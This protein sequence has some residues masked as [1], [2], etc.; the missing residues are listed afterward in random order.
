MNKNRCTK[1]DKVLN[2]KREVWLELDYETGKYSI[3]GKEPL[4]HSQGGF[5]FGTDC[6]EAV[7]NG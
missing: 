7:L 6:A 2:P 3:P 4:E 5:P 1:C